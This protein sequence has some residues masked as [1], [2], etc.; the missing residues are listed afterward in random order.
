VVGHGPHYSLPVEVY[1]GRPIFFGLG[2]LTF[3]TGHG[4][5]THAGWIG[6]LVA[7]TVERGKA[8]ACDFRF[9]RSNDADESYF[10]R[11][12]DESETLDDLAARSGKL[13]ARFEVNG[14][15]VR[16]LS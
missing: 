8:A 7:L 13:N 6:M 3:N 11:P 1:K 5:R 2:N 14:D 15:R 12:A 10:C 9:V 4:G 16:V